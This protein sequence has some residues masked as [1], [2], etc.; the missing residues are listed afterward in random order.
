MI[1]PN[2]NSLKNEKLCSKADRGRFK[3][4][5]LSLSLPVFAGVPRS[6]A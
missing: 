4:W 1:M 3:A 2:D 5:L 6:S